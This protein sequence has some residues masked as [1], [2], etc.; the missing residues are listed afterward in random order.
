M[1]PY[2]ICIGILYYQVRFT[3]EFKILINIHIYINMNLIKAGL[4]GVG[5]LSYKKKI[6]NYNIDTA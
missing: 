6:S 1:T 5:K 2:D 4:V 3:Q